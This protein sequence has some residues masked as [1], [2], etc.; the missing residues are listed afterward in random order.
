MRCGCRARD[1]LHQ[2]VGLESMRL[3]VRLLPTAATAAILFIVAVGA[4]ALAET[5]RQK[6]PPDPWQGLSDAGQEAQIQ[7]VYD[8]QAKF[9][10]DFDAS[11]RD[12]RSLPREAGEAFYAGPESLDDALG[13]SDVV[14]LATVRK[15]SF[16]PIA[17]QWLGQARVTIDVLRVLKGR[18][19]A[20]LELVQPGSAAPTA[21][22]RGQL[23]ELDVAPVLMPDDRVLLMLRTV[24]S[25]DSSALTPLEGAGIVYLE[26]GQAGVLDRS[27]LRSLLAGQ[28]ESKLLDLYSAALSPAK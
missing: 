18:A 22:G 2:Q 27:P 14:V 10:R 5:A 25:V 19:G 23:Q 8:Q 3:R 7:A 11:G 20:T 21:D 28:A 12:P 9:I 17:G 4:V 13:A 1:P 6:L 16:E 26:G 15:V 24:D